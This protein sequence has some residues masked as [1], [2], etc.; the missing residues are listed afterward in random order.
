MNPPYYLNLF[1]LQKAKEECEEKHRGANAAL[2]GRL[3][4]ILLLVVAEQQLGVYAMAVDADKAITVL[5]PFSVSTSGELLVSR[6]LAVRAP[7]HVA[8]CTIVHNALGS[9][10]FRH[11]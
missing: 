6:C 2:Y 4:Y 11:L 10:S 9:F 3:G 5:E 1:T 7:A 8:V